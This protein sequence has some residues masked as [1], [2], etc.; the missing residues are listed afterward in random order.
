M[1]DRTSAS[2]PSICSGDMYWKV[3]TSVPSAV[4]GVVWVGW[5]VRDEPPWG[6]APGL[7]RPKSMSLAPDWRQHDVAGL[8]VA[9]DEAPAVGAVQRFGDLDADFLDLLGGQGAALEALGQRLALQQLHD[10]E[11][12]A[13]LVAHVVECADV[14]VAQARDGLRLPLEALLE[15]RVRREVGRQDLDRDFAVKPRV[16]R[17]VD[18][19]HP[20]RA[21]GGEDFVG[22]Q[23]C[24]ACQR[25]STSSVINI[26]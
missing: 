7:A 10:Q 12:H 22:T 3:P 24:S 1:S 20:A 25:H 6:A 8:E 26:Q 14:R 15:V 17:P 5:A 9:V 19:A 18:L 2:L 16:L 4:R 21:K 13:V 23:F 11:V